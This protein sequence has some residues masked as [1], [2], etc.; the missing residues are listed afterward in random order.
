M[1]ASA[2]SPEP[3]SRFR[4]FLAS[5]REWAVAWHRDLGYFFSGAVLVYAISGLA[6][7]H[8]DHW[9]PNFV[10]TRRAVTLPLPPEPDRVTRELVEEALLRAGVTDAYRGHDFPSSR[11][12]KV[13]TRDG[14]VLVNLA[15]GQGEYEAARRRPVLYQL[16]WLHLHPRSGWRVFSDASSVALLVITVTGLVVSRGRHGFRRRG[17]WL[18]LAGV[19]LP[20]LLLAL[21]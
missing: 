16:N 3:A 2:P 11:K 13:F 1:P 20:A 15:D 10:I 18:V 14:S 17:W 4:R 9:N 6:L 8:V 21:G 7:N 12:V 19:A 5:W